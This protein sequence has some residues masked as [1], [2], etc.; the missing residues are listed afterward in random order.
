MV[1]P[2]QQKIY[3]FIQQYTDDNGFSPSLTE[4]ASGIGISPNSISLISRSIHTL[5]AAGRLRFHKKGYRS[6]QVVTDKRFTLPVVGRIAAGVPIE[7]IED[8]QLWI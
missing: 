6:I 3:T 2:V 5:V 1:T 8:Q 7:A 4:I